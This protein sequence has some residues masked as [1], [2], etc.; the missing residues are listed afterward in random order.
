M[1]WWLYPFSPMTRGL[2]QDKVGNPYVTLGAILNMLNLIIRFIPCFEKLRWTLGLVSDFQFVYPFQVVWRY[3][4]LDMYQSSR[5][6]MMHNFLHHTISNTLCIIHTW[7][8]RAVGKTSF[9]RRVHVWFTLWCCRGHF[10]EAQIHSSQYPSW[11]RENWESGWIDL[12]VLKRWMAM[13]WVSPG[14]AGQL[15]IGMKPLPAKFN[16]HSMM[17]K[18]IANTKPKLKEAR[19]CASASRGWKEARAFCWPG[20][21]RDILYESRGFLRHRTF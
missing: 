18:Y 8:K 13:G 10:N 20:Q 21:F 1:T 16:W 19:A 17:I 15:N 4:G 14:M 9:R 5:I 2:W 7:W 12:P 11:T 3:S 6:S